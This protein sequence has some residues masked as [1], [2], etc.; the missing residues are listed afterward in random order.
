MRVSIVAATLLVSCLGA[1]SEA[2]AQ[3]GVIYE[4]CPGRGCPDGA[5][6]ADYGCPGYVAVPLAPPTGDGSKE[7]I[8]DKAVSLISAKC[9]T[10]S[11]IGGLTTDLETTLS[12]PTSVADHDAAERMLQE[13]R[14]VG[15]AERRLSRFRDDWIR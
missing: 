14:A 12:V 3:D 1:Y 13:L 9:D 7:L 4:G 15:D 8:A 6:P 11:L 5:A 10:S 2:A